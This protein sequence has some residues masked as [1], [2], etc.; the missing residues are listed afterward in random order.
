MAFF[1]RNGL[2]PDFHEYIDSLT[3]ATPYS[4]YQP[5]IDWFDQPEVQANMAEYDYYHPDDGY[6][7]IN[8]NI[9]IFKA[10]GVSF[11]VQV[12]ANENVHPYFGPVL[13]SPIPAVSVQ[14]SEDAPS[15]S[16]VYTG[17]QGTILVSGQA[18]VQL[19]NYLLPT[20]TEQGFGTTPGITF[21]IV[22]VAEPWGNYHGSLLPY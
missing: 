2:M 3:E 20:F 15:S 19:D 16:G 9:P 22:Y 18:G 13:M 17:I 1:D 8:V 14:F 5:S 7:D 4:N 11:G 21:S 10:I 6:T 12:D